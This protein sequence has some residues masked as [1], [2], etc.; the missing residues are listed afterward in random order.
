MYIVKTLTNIS[1]IVTHLDTAFQRLD[2]SV[3]SCGQEYWRIYCV[4]PPKRSNIY[5]WA[6]SPPDLKMETDALSGNI[7]PLMNLGDRQCLKY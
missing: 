7:V 4:R 6:V 3:S 5:Y 1:N 2:L